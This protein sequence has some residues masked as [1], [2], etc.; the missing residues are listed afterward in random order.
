MNKSDLQYLLINTPLTDPTAPYHSISYLVGAAA[1]AG[2]TGFACLDA[3]IAALTYLAQ[4]PRVAA[5]LDLAAAVRTA[6]EAKPQLTRLDQLSYRYALK[7]VGLAPD[8]VLR[9]IAVMRDP[10]T[11]YDYSRYREAVMVL[12]RWMDLMSLAGVPGQFTGFTINGAGIANLNHLGD[13]TDDAGLRRIVGPFADYFDGPFTALLQSRPWQFVGLSVNYTAQ[14]PFA[15]QM[16]KVIR[17]AC[18]TAII[19]LGGT[20]I[21]DTLKNMLDPQQIWSLFPD[22]DVIVA[23]EGETALVEILDAIGVGAPLP[24]GRPALCCRHCPSLPAPP[25]SATKTSPRCPRRATTSGTMICTGRRSRSF[26]TRRRGAA[27]GTNAPSAI[28]G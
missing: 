10:A 27:T 11:F 19:A 15:M 16:C 2:Y 14:L 13:L 25:R 20:E 5:L 4:E 21:T 22:G 7:G 3:N 9:A 23:G 28:M 24:V 26:S 1:G 6:I 17:A 18:P 8:S 12:T